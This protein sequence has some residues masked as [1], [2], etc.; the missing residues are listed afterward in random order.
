MYIV[1]LYQKTICNTTLTSQFS[2]CNNAFGTFKEAS[3][4]ADSAKHHDLCRACFN[5]ARLFVPLRICDDRKDYCHLAAAPQRTQKGNHQAMEE[6]AQAAEGSL[7]KNQKATGRRPISLHMMLCW[8][9]TASFCFTK[10]P[11]RLCYKTAGLRGYLLLPAIGA[12]LVRIEMAHSSGPFAF[13]ATFCRA[14]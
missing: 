1:Y 9:R 7:C 3:N 8:P 13:L 2:E 5:S 10:K 12:K 11:R 4:A 6:A 14:F